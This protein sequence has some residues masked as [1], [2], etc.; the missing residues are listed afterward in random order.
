[1]SRKRIKKAKEAVDLF[2]RSIP[3]NSYFNVISF[4]GIFEKLWAESRKYSTYSA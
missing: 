2:I 4:G 3:K 1:M